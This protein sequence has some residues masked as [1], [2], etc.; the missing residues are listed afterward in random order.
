MK[1]ERI[2]I[3]VTDEEKK[4]INIMADK[5]KMNTSKFVYNAI[6]EK[7]ETE[8]L[9]DSQERF[10]SL[11]DVAF[12][13]SNESYF[14]QLMVTLNRIDFNSR[15]AIKQQDIFMQHLKVPQTKD[16]IHLS[17]IDHPI[18]EIAQEEVLKDIRNMSK[19]K[20]A[21]EDE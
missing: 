11:F 5:Y 16:D 20:K 13:K 7:L 19:R 17:I 18:T 8:K 6:R 10:L 3:R 9:S 2:T 15:W 12:K 21:L 4:E 1:D 14:K